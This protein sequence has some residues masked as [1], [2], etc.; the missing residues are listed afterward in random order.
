MQV[1]TAKE[2]YALM[3]NH[4]ENKVLLCRRAQEGFLVYH[5]AHWAKAFAQRLH[6]KAGPS[7]VYAPLAGLLDSYMGMDL[8]RFGLD[9]VRATRRFCRVFY[10]VLVTWVF[11]C[12]LRSRTLQCVVQILCKKMSVKSP[13]FFILFFRSLWYGLQQWYFSMFS[14]EL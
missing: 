12:G 4:G 6:K 13:P 11:L 2:A 10:S 5:L 9:A 3:H 8:K 7:S 1:L 14:A